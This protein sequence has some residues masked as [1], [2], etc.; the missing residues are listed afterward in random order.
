LAPD[1]NR[2]GSAII[3]SVLLP[4][5]LAFIMLTLGL[6][7][8][9]RDFAIVFQRPAGLLAGLGLQLLALP[10]FAALIVLAWPLPPDLAIG[11]MVIAAAPGGI[12]SNLLT[13]LARADT[14]LSI[15]L[16][17]ASSLI[18]LVTIPLVA[19]AA[20]AALG[21]GTSERDLALGTV[22]R[23]V[24]IVA[25]LP[26]AAGMLVRRLA[27]EIAI[28]L[29]RWARPAAVA[30]FAAIVIA[31]F[32]SQWP[33]MVASIAVLGPAV[34]ALNLGIIALALAVAVAVGLARRQMLALAIEGGLRNAA[35]GILVGVTLLDR[36]AIAVPSVTYA[37]IMNLTVLALVA[38]ARAQGRSLR[39]NTS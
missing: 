36:P 27:P 21:D 34:L 37:L 19:A 13:S 1:Q 12:T 14:A 25:T 17:A 4:A 24:L 26:V 10:A 16:T 15:T 30:I 39:R 31:T 2:V 32:V 11:L 18:S 3:Q 29:E 8:D 28:S 5:G 9:W 20:V 33:V 6:K 38:A 22:L 35:L 7:L 23:G